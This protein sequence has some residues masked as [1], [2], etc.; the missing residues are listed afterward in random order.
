MPKHLKFIKHY[1]ILSVLIIAI[2]VSGIFFHSYLRTE[3]FS[4]Q[5][6]LKQARSLFKQVIVT[7]RWVTE[8]GGIFVMVRPNV[9]PHPYLTQIPGLDV[10]HIDDKGRLYTLRNPGLVTREI[11]EIANELG[12]CS[13]HISSLKP[14]NKKT[15]SPD[16]FEE[17][18]LKLFEKG[19]REFSEVQ[20]TKEGSVFRY[21]A[22]LYFEQSCNKCHAHQGY[23]NG[24][25]RGGISI[26][27]PMTEE[28][29][30]LRSN[31]NYVILSAVL[32]IGLLFGLLYL[33]SA[34]FMK[35]LAE[36][37]GKLTKMAT[38]DSL[39]GLAN[40][41]T[42]ISRLEEELSRHYRMQST[43]SIL[44]IDIDHFKQVND[45][46]GHLAGDA[47][48]LFFANILKKCMRSYDVVCRYGG[49]EFLVI[50]PEANLIS[51]LAVAQKIRYLLSEETAVFNNAEIKITTS[52]GVAALNAAIDETTDS[53]IMRADNA[54]YKA[55]AAGRD[56]I[57]A[58]EEAVGSGKPCA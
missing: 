22:P 12:L 21:M 13:F 41:V 18:A 34:R 15:N 16:E 4:R 10:N 5:A 56:K 17:K 43:L 49:E 8:H 28:N 27:I 25:I 26:T 14:I 47:V 44:M 32:I 24:D 1:V 57:I 19:E 20:Q 6:L 31:L 53:F 35:A 52:I 55:K 37:H 58:A 45:T 7:R 39:T 36:A 54:L 51:A 2:T 48:L 11:S 33:I 30:E 3:H 42:G 38:T 50:L 23:K 9:N 40:R 29:A 46:F